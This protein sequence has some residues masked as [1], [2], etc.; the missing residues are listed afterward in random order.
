MRSL[1]VLIACVLMVPTAASAAWLT[2]GDIESSAGGE[3]SSITGWGPNGAWATHANFARPNNESLGAK[4]G[5]MSAQTTETVGQKTSAVFEV[6]MTY[7]FASWANPADALGEIIYQI[8]Y[9]DGTGAFV[10]LQS[11]PYNIDTTQSP[12]PWVSLAGVTYTTAA[13]GP[14]V[15]KTV[16]V[17]LGDG[18][19]G[20]PGRSDVW[21]DNLSL[22]VVPEPTSLVL[23][24]VAAVGLLRRR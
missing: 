5:Y 8:G 15:G 21:F 3:F 14:E 7:T 22:T 23:L 19:A 9:D 10:L 11:Q 12:A 1:T 4:F 16:W 6:G 17:R 2:N 13:G 24:G 20:D 18:V